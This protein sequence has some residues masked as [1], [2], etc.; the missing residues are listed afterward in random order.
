MLALVSSAVASEVLPI[1]A[2]LVNEIFIPSWGLNREESDLML[3]KLRTARMNP[4]Y[5]TML[6]DL[7][8]VARNFDP[9]PFDPSLWQDADDALAVE[10]THQVLI[11]NPYVRIL[12]VV[13]PSGF[14]QDYHTHRWAGITV[15]LIPSDFILYSNGEQFLLHATDDPIWHHDEGQPLHRVTN[16]GKTAYVGIHIEIKN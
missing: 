16:V 11:E 2:Q 6:T 9:K 3:A 12:E 14:D 15:D 5:E 4:D 10:P 7:Y 8:N 13:I 1:E